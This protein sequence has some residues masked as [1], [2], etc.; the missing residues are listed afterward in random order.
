M[1]ET[2][3]AKALWQRWQ[4]GA[5]PRRLLVPAGLLLGGLLL[6]GPLGAARPS[7]RPAR[8]ETAQMTAYEQTLESR[9]T[10][11]LSQ[12]EGV[13][14]VQV[15]LTLTGSPQHIY[16]TDTRQ[17]M[18]GTEQRHVLLDDGG[19]LTETVQTPEIGGAAILCEGGDN[20]RVAAQIYE[21]V[22]SLLGLSTGRI[23]VAKLS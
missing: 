21:I 13:G 20:V 2:Q 17:S 19:A 12:V 16:A 22:S 15:M 8:D 5:D 11:L 1:H 23:S 9:L 10:A 6:L 4:A 7:P 3:G 18:G 14:R